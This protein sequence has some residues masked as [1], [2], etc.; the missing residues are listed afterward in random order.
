MKVRVMKKA[1]LEIAG[2]KVMNT[3]KPGS[4]R[5]WKEVTTKVKEANLNVETG[6]GVSYGFNDKGA[7]NYMAGYRIKDVDAIRDLEFSTIDVM[8]KEYAVVFLKGKSSNT[9][10]AGW[11]YLKEEYIPR[12]NYEITKAP[13]VEVY[14]NGNRNSDDYEME[15][16]V[17]I[18]RDEF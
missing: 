12:K 7:F 16:W 18:K 14:Y 10:K 1:T 8:A 2:V 9:I 15:L 11:K 17:P 13:V 4:V 3:K 6:F 5:L